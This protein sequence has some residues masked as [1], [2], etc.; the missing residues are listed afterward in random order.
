V[1]ARLEDAAAILG[2]LGI[3]DRLFRARA[4]RPPSTTPEAAA[5]PW[6]I[7]VAPWGAVAI[8]VGPGRLALVLL[9][10]EDAADFA[11]IPESMHGGVEAII[12]LNQDDRGHLA[13]TRVARAAALGVVF[14]SVA[15]APVDRPATLAEGI[16]TQPF[17][18][19]ALSDVT[20]VRR[21][22]AVLAR[23]DDGRTALVGCHLRMPEI[24]EARPDYVVGTID[25]RP[26]DG[27]AGVELASNHLEGK[28]QEIHLVG[29][30][31]M[32]DALADAQFL[33]QLG[34]RC[35]VAG[36]RG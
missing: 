14:A 3:F 28:P 16:V 12:V 26:G 5:P 33:A 10:I 31:S 29:N 36:A 1:S 8:E 20:L 34:I 6:V 25:I 9:P 4:A 22:N 23:R 18:W 2:R 21:G 32:S 13:A 15:D 7:G 17:E 11:A 24:V 19:I 35:S 27:D 30:G